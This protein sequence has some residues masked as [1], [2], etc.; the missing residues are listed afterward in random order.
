MNIM[1]SIHIQK[2]KEL[3]KML[4]CMQCSINLNAEIRIHTGYRLHC[5]YCTHY[6]HQHIRS[7]T[8]VQNKLKRMHV[9][10]HQLHVRAWSYTMLSTLASYFFIK[11]CTTS[12]TYICIEVKDKYLGRGSY[13][14]Q[15]T[16]EIILITPMH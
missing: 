8:D 16:R 10:M 13:C 15:L 7:T 11:V 2:E 14:C 6:I 12:F 1:E 9:L 4:S 5:I 3:I